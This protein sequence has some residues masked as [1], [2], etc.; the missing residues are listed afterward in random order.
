MNRCVLSL[1]FIFMLAQAVM[2]QPQLSRR[3]RLLMNEWNQRQVA[4]ARTDNEADWL[5]GYGFEKHRGIWKTDALIEVV[6]GKTPPQ[7][8][9]GA[10]IRTKVG[11]IYTASLS[12][13][14]LVQL[15]KNK[16]LRLLELAEPMLPTMLETTRQ[17][18]AAAAH[19]GVGLSQSFEGKNTIIGVIDIGF[20]VTHPNFRT[21]DGSQ[22][23]ILAMW[24]QRDTLGA[25]PD[26]FS[27]GVLSE[28]TSALMAKKHDTYATSWSH[29]SLTAG[30]AAG[31]GYISENGFYRG[32]A[33][34]AN[35]VLVS[36][37]LNNSRV[38]DATRF[39]FDYAAARNMPAVVN[40]SFGGWTTP[41]DGTT[42]YDRAL[43]ELCGEGRIIVASMGNEGNNFQHIQ[44]TFT[45]ANDGVKSL[46]K[47]MPA[48][49]NLGIPPSMDIW[50]TG[51]KHFDVKVLLVDSAGTIKQQS[52]AFASTDFLEDTTVLENGLDSLII[53]RISTPADTNNGQP[54][55]F[56]ILVPRLKSLLCGFEMNPL[57]GSGKV[58]VYAPFMQI[59]DGVPSGNPFSGFS[60]G[61]QLG[62]FRTP[63]GTSQR[64]IGAGSFVVSTYVMNLLGDTAWAQDAFG[65]RYTSG[66]FAS[67]SSRGPNAAGLIRPDIVASGVYVSSSVSSFNWRE[68][69]G[70]DPWIEKEIQ[71][72]GRRYR[73]APS[74]GTS[75]AA[76]V[77]AGAVSLMLEANPKLTPEAVK[78]ILRI[79]ATRD[80][81]TGDLAANPSPLW[82]W[83]KLNVIEAI[84][85]AS[86]WQKTS[87]NRHLVYPNPAADKL[88]ISYP[89]PAIEASGKYTYRIYDLQGK[90]LLN[91]ERSPSMT[92]D[93]AVENFKPGI[94]LLVINDGYGRKNYRF[95]K[96]P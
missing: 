54:N 53:Y 71:F 40:M 41:F 95:S 83:G 4:F 84:K 30:M 55:Q 85:M 60:P 59:V 67:Y 32:I 27:Y 16:Q 76:P 23:K 86:N 77:I 69:D 66:E 46:F 70:K 38:I 19:A 78:T 87:A 13:Q 33:P 81:F 47:N 74:S 91:Q 1:L 75:M 22:V 17:S 58:D 12:M 93:L 11:N 9:E 51:G 26:G 6:K 73:Y 18:G 14:A 8:P 24:D 7:W 88:Y 72:E 65:N 44:K 89:E 94:Y 29:G 28:G 2:A 39:I 21:S 57:E 10:E 20:D 49:T 3:T 52:R 96:R 35:L 42:A 80:A 37:P 25:P 62:N 90:L 50:G 43:S 63:G 64:V 48:R 45:H 15:S 56:F 68:F 31:S 36:S 61:D 82:G 79:S 5:S 34:E 92:I